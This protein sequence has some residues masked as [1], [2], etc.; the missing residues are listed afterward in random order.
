[1]KNFY[2]VSPENIEEFLSIVKDCDKNTRILAGGTDVLTQLRRGVI[3][4]ET[5]VNIKKI[6]SLNGICKENNHLKLGALTKIA[7]ICIDKQ[8]QESFPLLSD[9]A[10]SLASPLIRNI[11][12]IG[13]N[14]C[15]ASPAGDMIPP[16]MCY[17]AK[18]TV[19]AQEGAKEYQIENFFN[20]P[21]ITKMNSGDL[22]TKICISSQS[23]KFTHSFIKHGYRKSLE[24][25]T[26]CVATLIELDEDNS[27]KDIRIALGS[28]APCVFRL[29]DAEEL[30]KQERSIEKKLLE[31]VAD[32]AHEKSSPIDDIRGT[33]E[34]RSTVLKTLVKRSIIEA[35]N[36]E[37]VIL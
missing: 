34:Y 1:M 18:L 24:I 36:K 26:V 15:N 12:T 11:A 19:F 35:L 2:Y 3:R 31:K 7:E 32:I 5:L 4:A 13:G 8:V 20:G 22:L 37:G 16:L 23:G 17:D 29:R 28:V 6:D 25:S 14:I 10:R 30:I 21:G 27:I 9:A 33:K